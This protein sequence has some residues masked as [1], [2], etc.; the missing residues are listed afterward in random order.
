M[1]RTGPTRTDDVTGIV[2]AAC[3]SWRE[4]AGQVTSGK[5]F[6]VAV[7]AALLPWPRSAVFLLGGGLSSGYPVAFPQSAT[8][9][10]QSR[11]REM[12]MADGVPWVETAI[13]V[14]QALIALALFV[15]T[16]TIHATQMRTQRASSVH[17]WGVACIDVLAEA[18][19]LLLVDSSAKAD[20]ICTDK[21]HQLLHR[22]SALTDRGRMFFE[23]SHRESF[24]QDRLPAY[25]GLRPKI[26]DP[27]VAANRALEQFQDPSGLPDAETHARLREWRRYFVSLLQ[28]EV[29]PAWLKRATA[30]H[31]DAGGGAGR[32]V[33]GNSV[34]PE[35]ID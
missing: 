33:D 25:R 9:A 21:R 15:L 12:R 14:T 18:D 17:E 13:A 2:E 6:P 20:S 27:L 30:Y 28:V 35:T 7:N 29:N 4:E 34:A 8:M 11:V 26:L 1:N 32:Q 5:Y 22:L 10:R 3:P 16:R 23:N 24:G 19:R 31:E